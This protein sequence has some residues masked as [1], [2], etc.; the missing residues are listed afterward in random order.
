MANIKFPRK[1]FEKSLGKPINPEIERKIS[2]F[3]TPL[4]SLTSEEIEIEI[5][6]NRPDLLSLQGYIRSFKS[7]LVKSSGLIKYGLHAPQKNYSVRIDPSVNPV[8]P[9]TVCA[10]VKNLFFNEKKIKEIVDL[11]EKLHVTIGRNRKKVALGIYPLEKIKL[12]IRYTTKKPTEIKFIPLDAKREMNAAQIL[13]THPKGKEY[14]EL[15]KGKDKYP[16]FI[17]SGNKIL[18]MPPVINNEETGKVT[19]STREVFIEVS[20]YDLHLLNKVLNIVVTSLAEM[21]G[22]I[23]QMN[24]HYTSP[25]KKLITPNLDTQKTKIS[26][27]NVNKLLGLNLKKPDLQKLLE[28]MGHNY[29]KSTNTVETPSWRTDILHEVDLI[30]DVAIAYGYENFVPKIP[31]IATTGEE[32]KHSKLQS[33][34]SETLVGLGILEI[35]S[36]HLIKED[37]AK[38]ISLPKNQ[39]IELE[40]SKTEYKIL[41]PNLLIPVLRIL[42]ENKDNEYPQNIFEIGTIF[43]K[44]DK[45]DTQIKEKTNLIIALTPGNFTEAKQHLDYLFRS[46]K[47]SYKLQETTNLALIDGRTG[48]IFLNNKPIGY[49]GEVHPQTLRSLT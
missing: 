3:G 41:R 13:R 15:L 17:D 19:H 49:L 5:F 33:K 28:K 29:K 6:P 10:I 27:E 1:E 37:E 46:L 48:A 30:E 12:P 8:R 22:K 42:S 11:Q 9:Y 35:S 40:E 16:I 7:F 2:L 26:L 47:L 25:N 21:G 34:I 43:K 23:Y 24:L 20:G 44:N 38:K 4:E 39:K 31:D 14:A 36:Y 32:T 45:L 18:S